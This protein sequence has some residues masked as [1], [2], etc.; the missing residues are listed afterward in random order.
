M[1]NCELR[2]VYAVKLSHLYRFPSQDQEGIGALHEKPRKLSCEDDLH[3]VGLFDF[4]AGE[5]HTAF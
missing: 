2:T 3:L 5:H 4:Y 1:T